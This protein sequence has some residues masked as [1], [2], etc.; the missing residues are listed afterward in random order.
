MRNSHLIL[1]LTRAKRAKC[2]PFLLIVKM[3][4]CYFSEEIKQE[5]QIFWWVDDTKSES[6]VDLPIPLKTCR[7]QNQCKP[8]FLH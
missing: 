2:L 1:S 5:R 7:F 6:G 4:C 3:L 8:H